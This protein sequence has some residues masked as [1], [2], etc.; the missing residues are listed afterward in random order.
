MEQGFSRAQFMLGFMYEHGRGVARDDAN[1]VTW[2][3]RAAD[4]GNA[5]AQCNLGESVGSAAKAMADER[6]SGDAR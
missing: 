6:F 2:Y 5:T 1:A 3:R 4:Q